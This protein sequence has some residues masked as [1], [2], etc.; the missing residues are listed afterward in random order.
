[1]EH[2][3]KTLVQQTV[4]GRGV[5]YNSKRGEASGED[6]VEVRGINAPDTCFCFAMAPSTVI[7]MRERYFGMQC[8]HGLQGVV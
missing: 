4:K 8:E 1:M 6:V 3:A 5:L 7:I 2:R